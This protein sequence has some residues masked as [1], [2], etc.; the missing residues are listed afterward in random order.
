MGIKCFLVSSSLSGPSACHPQ[1]G[2][3]SNTHRLAISTKPA[4]LWS[5]GHHPPA[6][7]PQSTWHLASLWPLG[8][9]CCPQLG[10]L[11]TK[12]LNIHLH[13]CTHQ[14]YNTAGLC[15]S[16]TPFRLTLFTWFSVPLYLHKVTWFWAQIKAN[17]LWQHTVKA[18]EKAGS[19][20]MMPV[21]AHMPHSI[22]VWSCLK[23]A[24]ESEC[25]FVSSSIA[26]WAQSLYCAHA[27]PFICLCLLVTLRCLVLSL[28]PPFSHQ[29]ACETC[30]CQLFEMFSPIRN[31][32]HLCRFFITSPALYIFLCL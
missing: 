24:C 3:T 1:S 7:V 19:L 6:I 28:F 17:C 25:L 29:W 4:D 12:K 21:K 2:T 11:P 18:T 32:G 5:S 8:A 31:T 30:L 14:S 20:Y 9:C 26:L 22:N 27:Q 15:L 16:L 10:P 13:L 23:A